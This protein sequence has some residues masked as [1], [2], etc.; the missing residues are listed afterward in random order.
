MIHL[1]KHGASVGAL[2]PDAAHLTIDYV[3]V[4][5]PAQSRL[6]KRYKREMKNFLEALGGPQEGEVRLGVASDM[7]TRPRNEDSSIGLLA[8]LGDDTSKPVVLVAVA[9]GMGG[10]ADGDVASAIAIEAITGAMVE[11]LGNGSGSTVYN[12]RLNPT[13]VEG[14]LMGAVAAAHNEIK[15]GTAGGGCTVTCALIAGDTATLAHVG[16]SRAYLLNT[17]RRNI[18]LITHDHL[19]VRAWQDAGI[20]TEEQTVHHPQRHILYRSIGRAERCEVDLGQRSL[21]PGSCLLLCSDGVWDV[22]SRDEIARIV[23]QSEHPQ[24]ACE[25][26]INAAVTHGSHDDVTAALVELPG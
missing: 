8:H 26:L 25:R 12:Q 2:S 21:A 16:D 22:L 6:R 10:H 24:E 17:R 4:Q 15:A 14:M 7:G 3:R 5:G 11:A 23:Y 13:A 19:L 9:D 20:I 18:E 1:P